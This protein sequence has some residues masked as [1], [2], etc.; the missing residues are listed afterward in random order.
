MASRQ[1]QTPF[2]GDDAAA[3]LAAAADRKSRPRPEARG[4][5]ASLVPSSALG[6]GWL[7]YKEGAVRWHIKTTR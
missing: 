7:R 6:S 1:F 4:S 2:G 5:A 3:Y